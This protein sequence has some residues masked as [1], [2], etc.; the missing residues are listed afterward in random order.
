M[1][2]LNEVDN[3]R[4]KVTEDYAKITAKNYY[5]GKKS[6][7]SRWKMTLELLQNLDAKLFLYAL[8]CLGDIYVEFDEFE[9]AKNFFFYFKFFA[10]YMELLEEVMISYESLGNVYKFLFQYHKAIKCYK[11]Q[12]E[13]AWILNNKVSELRAYDNIGIQYFY[14]GN[15]DK[16]KYYHERM[17]YGRSENQKSDTRESVCKYYKNKNFHMFNDEKYIRNIRNNDEL[18]D[19][20][21]ESLALFEENKSID[22]ETVD[23]LKNQDNMK[24][25]FISDVDMTFSVIPEKYLSEDHVFHPVMSKINMM[26]N[27]TNG[28]KKS[29][30]KEKYQ[31]GISRRTNNV[32]DNMILSHL[33][34]KRKEFNTDRFRKIFESFDKILNESKEFFKYS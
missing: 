28:F 5:K 27:N 18:K 11:K 20:L 14:L 32:V 8:K 21:R 10:N 24:N 29:K 33:S 26:I 4:N 1:D 25:S 17:L 19:K 6:I 13:I 30:A 3:I 23:I 22:L 16:A 7:I 9:L 2:K 34:T 15:R 12:I 31:I